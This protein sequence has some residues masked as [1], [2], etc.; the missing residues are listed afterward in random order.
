MTQLKSTKKGLVAVASLL[1]LT[2]CNDMGDSEEEVIVVEETAEEEEQQ[3]VVTPTIQTPENFYRNVLVDGTYQHSEARGN[4]AHAMNNRIDIDQFEVGLMEI[5][6][7]Q[8][9]QEEYYFQ[10]GRLLDGETIN[11]WLRRYDPSEERYQFGLNPTLPSL[12]AGEDED[13]DEEGKTEEE[14]DKTDEELMRENPAYLSHIMEHNYVLEAEDD[15]VQLGGI[16]IG[17]SLRSVYYFRTV[18]EEGGYWFHQEELD[19]Q[20]VEAAGR[21]MADEVVS[22]MRQFQEI[23]DVP[24]TVA[25]YQEER[26]DAIVPGNFIAVGD[27]GVG[28]HIEEWEPVDE[29]FHFFPPRSSDAPSAQASE[30]NNFKADIEDFFEDNIGVVGKGRYKN[31]DLQEF[32]IDINLQSHGQAEVIALTQFISGRLDQHFTFNAPID[33]LIQSTNGPEA[34][35]VEHP[36]QEPFVHIY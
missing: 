9:P 17:L 13:E 4:V 10:E 15:G 25:L 21:E 28:D 31:N 34:L 7:S 29:E 6:S 1:M 24:I 8:F 3:Y 11:S 5:A 33:I 36:D 26:R 16:V 27:A 19:P 22:R 18:D 32:S 14:E 2:G 23:E 12:G 20:E 30:F 35:I